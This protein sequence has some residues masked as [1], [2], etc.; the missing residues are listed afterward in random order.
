MSKRLTTEEWVAKAEARHGKGRYDYSK[1]QYKSSREKVEIIC[2]ECGNVFW[3]NPTKHTNKRGDGCPV[4]A[5]NTASERLM[6]SKET[7]IEKAESVH[8]KGKYDYSKVVYTGDKGLL[9]IIC[10]KHNNLFTQR[11]GKHIQGH[12]CPI[13]GEEVRVQKRIQAKSEAFIK[14]VKA[15]H[16]DLYNLDDLVYTGRK[17]KVILGCRLHGKVEVLASSILHSGKPAGCPECGKEKM[18]AARVG[19]IDTFKQSVRSK[20]SEEVYDYTDT[21]YVNAKTPVKVKCTYCK[22]DIESTPDSLLTRSYSCSC[23]TGHLPGGFKDYLPGTLYYLR[24]T[25]EENR[26]SYK[27]GITNRTVEER[28]DARDLA[29][30][31]IIKT[32]NYPKGLDA[33]KE[34]RRIL[35]DFKVYKVAGGYA[36]LMSGNTELFDRDILELDTRGMNE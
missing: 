31:S 6:S 14:Q 26:V 20:Y 23:V 32:W 21:V 2:N 17:N 22:K 19:S 15:I 28:C 7:F 30:I 8:G 29:K 4:C 3:Q 1:V 11:A 36:P 12:G 33:R 34:E 18:V 24:V 5:R 35:N 9:D 25:D 16:G 10:L 13:C 27:I